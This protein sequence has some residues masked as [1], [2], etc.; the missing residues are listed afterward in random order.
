[1]SYKHLHLNEAIVRHLKLFLGFRVCS[2]DH[3]ILAPDPHFL[4]YCS[5]LVHFN[6]WQ[7]KVPF[8][9]FFID[10]FFVAIFIRLFFQMNLKISYARGIL[11]GLVLN[12][13]I[14][15][16]RFTLQST[17]FF[18]QFLSSFV[19][20]SRARACFSIGRSCTFLSNFM[21]T[22]LCFYRHC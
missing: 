14:N 3:S 11:I 4:N 8:S 18:Y 5:L 12:L 21:L 1:M 15:L 13:E 6:T 22:L 16:G 2:T 7:C 10:I 17:T 9:F 19:S 20:F